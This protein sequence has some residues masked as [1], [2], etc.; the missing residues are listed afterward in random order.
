MVAHAGAE[1][2]LH[3]G[4]ALSSASDIGPLN[5]ALDETAAAP[6]SLFGSS[7]VRV[8]ARQQESPWQEPDLS[9]Y[10]SV[11]L[12]AGAD[13][14]AIARRLAEEESVAG[15]YVKAAPAL[16]VPAA[17]GGAAK[18]VERAAAT[19]ALLLAATAD[20]SGRQTYLDAPPA[21]V[22][23]RSSWTRPG[24][25]GAG[26]EVMTVGGAWRLAHED[27]AE[28][29]HAEPIAGTQINAVNFRNHGTAML[30]VVRADRNAFGVTGIAP[31]CR[32]RQ[33]ATFGLGTAG[34]INAAAN[35][36]HPGDV[37]LL[38]WMRPG[39]GS[40]GV[41]ST[42]FIA[43]EW[44][45]DDFAAI[46]AAT[47]RGVIVVA[48]AGNGSVDF[49]DPRYTQPL[50]GFPA[51]WRNPF[52]RGVADCGSLLVG[53]GS[54]PDGTHGRPQQVDR[55][56]EDFS[57]YGSSID[58]QGWGAEVTTLAYGDLQ[59]GDDENLWYTDTFGGTSAAAAM[60]AGVV[61][62]LQ[63]VNL[64]GGSKRAPLTP[65]QARQFLR[66]C[67]SPQQDGK[68]PA[69]QRIGSRPELL[70]LIA[71]LPPPK[72]E[73][74]DGKDGKNEG[75]DGKDGKDPKDGKDN[76]DTKN[77]KDNTDSQDRKNQKDSKDH[78][79]HKDDKSDKAETT[80]ERKDGFAIEKLQGIEKQNGPDN[81]RAVESFDPAGATFSFG[82]QVEDPEPVQ[83]F[84]PVAQRPNL[85]TAALLDEPDLIGS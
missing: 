32:A 40:T 3:A 71:M 51:S 35:A 5:L 37:L 61:A 18:A 84:I 4:R 74:K 57:N 23:A 17:G 76:P 25:D 28:L 59:G 66:A 8:R 60:V 85:A 42:G 75:K 6:R 73:G 50:P 41:G 64:G 43:I 47:A 53:A 44:W 79:D 56:R 13:H 65:G 12:E 1:L 68:N 80:K 11:P 21:G 46:Q 70:A 63:G 2:R 29:G 24:G 22:N 69:T 54:P 20:F 45:P 52:N 33:V 9:V 31:A 10:Y 15:A 14:Q 77:A 49:D 78:K 82:R 27:L 19:P 62:A 34:A 58:V 83:H 16:H 55:S 48:P 39:P 36:L 30:G 67:G 81:Q 72:D 38:E 26:V 7:E